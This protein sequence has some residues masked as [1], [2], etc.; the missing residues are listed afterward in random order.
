MCLRNRL[1]Q[2]RTT[3]TGSMGSNAG[4]RY[5]AATIFRLAHTKTIEAPVRPFV[6]EKMTAQETNKTNKILMD[7]NNHICFLNNARIKR[8]I[9]GRGCMCN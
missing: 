4:C 7:E 6:S 8:L 1:A 5:S 9:V 3:S 2:I